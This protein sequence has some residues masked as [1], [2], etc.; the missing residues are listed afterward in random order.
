MCSSLR[1]SVIDFH[2]SSAD[3]ADVVQQKRMTWKNL[4]RYNKNVFFYYNK[5][6][7]QLKKCIFLL[8]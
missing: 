7:K 3:P 8:Y 1:Q 5:K 6:N 2:V 4:T